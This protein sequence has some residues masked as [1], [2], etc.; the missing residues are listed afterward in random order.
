MGN[1]WRHSLAEVLL[2]CGCTGQTGDPAGNDTL[3]DRFLRRQS[4]AA[5]R[6]ERGRKGDSVRAPGRPPG[7]GVNKNTNHW[8][9]FCSTTTLRPARRWR[10]EGGDGSTGFSFKARLAVAD[11]R[12]RRLVAERA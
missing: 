2:C 8:F 4:R 1:L 5:V 12:P 10:C 11:E 7:S 9:R 3:F 6:S